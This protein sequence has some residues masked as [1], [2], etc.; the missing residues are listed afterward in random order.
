MKRL[1]ACCVALGMIAM[2]SA[3][4]A[5]EVQMDRRIDKDVMV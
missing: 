4:A 3:V 2:A 1:H 5:G